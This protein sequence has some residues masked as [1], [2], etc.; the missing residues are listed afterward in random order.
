MIVGGHAIP[1]HSNHSATTAVGQSPVTNYT[2]SE[3]FETRDCSNL[4]GVGLI[5]TLS[6]LQIPYKIAYKPMAKLE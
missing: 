2:V 1:R 4:H 3:A 6:T 5:S